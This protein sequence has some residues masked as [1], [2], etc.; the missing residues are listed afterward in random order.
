MTIKKARSKVGKRIG[1]LSDK[2]LVEIEGVIFGC[3]P[4]KADAKRTVTWGE[5]RSWLA[6]AFQKGVGVGLDE[7]Q[8]AID[9]GGIDE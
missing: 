8:K 4:G 7:A 9:E 1:D 2:A 6:L 5:A 3:A